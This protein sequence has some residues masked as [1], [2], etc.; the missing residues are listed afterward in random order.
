MTL[1]RSL[2]NTGGGGITYGRYRGEWDASS[3]TPTLP[4]P[5]TS[6][7]FLEGDYY[8]C[9][10][11]GTQFSINF[12]KNDFIAVIPNGEA[13]A[14]SKIEGG[15]VDGAASSTD[16]AI[17]RFDGTSGKKIQNSG[18]TVSDN[19]D[20]A[21]AN[22][23]LFKTTPS[24]VPTTV[25]TVSWDVDY[26]TLGIQLTSSV[27]G[28]TLLA[29]FFYAKASAEITKGQL[30]YFTGAVGES[31]VIQVA[32]ATAGI[33]NPNY[34]VGIAAENIALNGFG[35]IQTFG[36]LKGLDT[37]SFNDGDILYYDPA[38]GGLASAFP[39]NGIVVVVCAV[40]KANAGAGIL[41]IRPQ[42]TQRV[43]SGNNAITVTQNEIGTEITYN[44]IQLQSGAILNT[45][46]SAR[47]SGYVSGTYN[48]VPLIN[49]DGTGVTADIEVATGGGMLG[50]NITDSGNNGT[51]IGTFLE[52]SVVSTTGNGSGA[53]IDITTQNVG[54]ILE[55]SVDNPG[56][57]GIDGVYDFVS[58]NGGS[59]FGA[60]ARVTITGGVMT[61]IIVTSGGNGYL[62]TDI[63]SVNA[64]ALL[65]ATATIVSIKSIAVGSA[66][67]S[68]LQI[69]QGYQLA[70]ILTVNS[71][72][73]GDVTGFTFSPGFVTDLGYVDRIKLV[74]N[75][76]DYATDN[77]LSVNNSDLG[78]SGSGLDITVT[79]TLNGWKSS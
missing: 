65:G 42:I 12:T 72:D 50:T 41:A 19:N 29:N 36:I 77:H 30:C 74:N 43:S 52:V 71:T 1:V 67:I 18:V 5:P 49:G 8:Q 70:D 24:S 60:M 46:F 53:K 16:N 6:P 22:S 32:P 68:G 45:T 44:G 63:L 37:S 64:G 57:S 54:Q 17:P 38:N 25:G 23:F 4:N 14:W 26:K 2:I 27:H 20:L 11:D 35:F 62:D 47:G 55:L 10:A 9:T 61:E 33:T 73:I 78:G 3:N 28:H 34:I 31:G 58:L 56:S 66:N 40:V 79:Q 75:G 39:A 13:F 69:G 7:D 48:N 59:G 21:N 51:T 76:S 15:S